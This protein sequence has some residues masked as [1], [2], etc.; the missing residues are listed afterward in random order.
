VPAGAVRTIPEVL[1]EPHLSDR[2][3]VLPLTPSSQGHTGYGLGL[4]FQLAD[5]NP[6]QLGAPPLLGEH[7]RSVLRELGYSDTEIDALQQARV[8]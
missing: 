5:N 7:T 2:N 1:S 3:L 4:G 8:I 6:A